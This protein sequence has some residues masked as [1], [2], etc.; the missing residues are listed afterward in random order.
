MHYPTHYPTDLDELSV[1]EHLKNLIPIVVALHPDGLV[2]RPIRGASE[3]IAAFGRG[4]RVV[5][6]RGEAA[7]PPFALADGGLVR[8]VQA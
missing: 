4:L 1:D 6:V 2:P 7:I 8:L 3:R 5:A